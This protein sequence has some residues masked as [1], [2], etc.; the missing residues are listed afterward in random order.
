MPPLAS[1]TGVHHEAEPKPGD[2][3]TAGDA[4]PAEHHLACQRRRNG[5]GQPKRKHAASVRCGDRRADHDGVT[6]RTLP[7]GNIG[8]HDGLAVTR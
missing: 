6:N 8:S 2:Q 1:A 3:Q 7:T 5:E 4:Q